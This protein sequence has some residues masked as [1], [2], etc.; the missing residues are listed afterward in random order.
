MIMP[1]KVFD[2]IIPL[3]VVPE[4]IVFLN[5]LLY[6]AG[7]FL[8]FSRIPSNICVRSFE[9]LRLKTAKECY[10]GDIALKCSALSPV[11]ALKQSPMFRIVKLQLV[12]FYY[13]LMHTVFR[14]FSLDHLGLRR[15]KSFRNAVVDLGNWY[16]NRLMAEKN[17][18]SHHLEVL[19]PTISTD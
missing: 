1:S 15:Q 7:V 10:I 3:Q 12:I 9:T 11:S 16:C 2:C 4:I 13:F 18:N 17:K 6:F 14:C 19:H 8:S 5:F